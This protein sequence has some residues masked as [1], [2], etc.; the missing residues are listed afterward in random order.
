[1][2]YE[3]KLILHFLL[4]L[5][6]LATDLYRASLQSIRKAA[7]KH[8]WHRETCLEELRLR[9]IE[10]DERVFVETE[11]SRSRLA[12]TNRRPLTSVDWSTDTGPKECVWSGVNN[13]SYEGTLL[14]SGCGILCCYCMALVWALWG[15]NGASSVHS[16]CERVANCQS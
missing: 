8:K 15:S 5:A 11:F 14:P 2:S 9:L 10:E 7:M 3:T 6:V 12:F 4:L 13:R 1:M 16:F